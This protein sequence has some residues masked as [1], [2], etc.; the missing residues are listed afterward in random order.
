MEAV[1][2]GH[3]KVLDEGVV[4]HLRGDW[5]IEDEQL[6]AD[7]QRRIINSLGFIPKLKIE[8][9]LTE[10]E[11]SERAERYKAKSRYG[12]PEI[13]EVKA[14]KAPKIP[15]I[16]EEDEDKGFTT[17]AIEEAEKKKPGRPKKKED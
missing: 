5:D 17:E 11:K 12:R 3:P 6:W 4:K 7:D 13:G 16:I 15:E 10:K 1:L 8:R 2:P 9:L 14:Q